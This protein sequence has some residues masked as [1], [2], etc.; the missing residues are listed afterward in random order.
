MGNR[1]ER[2]S[3]ENVARYRK[4][5]PAGL[6]FQSSPSALQDQECF[7]YIYCTLPF[8]FKYI[9]CTLPFLSP[10]VHVARWAHRR[11]FLSVCL[12]KKF[13]NK[14]HI[15]KSIAGS[16]MKFG[17][18][19]LDFL[20]SPYGF[21]TWSCLRKCKSRVQITRWAHCQRQVAFFVLN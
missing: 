2:H 17:R 10:P 12:Y 9:Y 19:M 7:K 16:H 3:L 20:L 14:I 13:K 18:T 21:F 4:D 15:S 11:H 5:N 1:E 8:C 6:Q